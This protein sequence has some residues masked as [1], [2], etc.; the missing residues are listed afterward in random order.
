MT[1][2]T[3]IAAVG[4][5]IFAILIGASYMSKRSAPDSVDQPVPP[6]TSAAAETIEKAT[7]NGESMWL[8]FRSTT[9]NPC[10]EMQK[11]FDQLEPEYKDKVRFIAIDVNDQA[12]IEILRVWRIQYIPTTF[13][14]D[15]TGEITY[16]NVGVIPT[17]DLKKELNKVVK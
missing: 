8:L 7:D 9:C 3:K 14:V 1:K 6:V 4:F 10:V 11:V 16:Q 15:S 12:N 13:I 2:G 17:E 5:L